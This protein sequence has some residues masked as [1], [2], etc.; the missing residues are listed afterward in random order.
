MGILAAEFG[1]LPDG[2]PVTEHTLTNRSG[3]SASILD[4]GGIVTRILVPDRFG[5]LGDVTLG[6][7]RFEGYLANPGFLGALVG[8]VGNRI[9]EGRFALNGI[10][11]RLARNAGGHHLHGGAVGF[12]AKLW[13]AEPYSDASGDHLRL[14]YTSPDGEEGYPGEL[15]VTVTYSWNEDNEL[16]IRYE[17]VSDRDTLCN[18]TNHAYFN[19]EGEGSGPIDG[20]FMTIFA[21]RI[22]AADRDL[23]P[24]GEILDV[25]GTPFDLRSGARIGDG[26]ARVADDELMGYGKGYD[27]NFALN[28]YG[29]GVRHVATASAPVS[30]RIMEMHTDLPGAQFYTAN[31]M[32]TALPGRCGRPYGPRD[33]FCFETQ[34]YPDSP[35]RPEFPDSVLRAGAA[36][37]SE[38]A[39]RFRHA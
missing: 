29:E 39:Y 14:R 6:Y 20:H 2:R 26:L 15:R 37:R 38:T 11:Y 21:D 22:T 34:F 19:L 18:L 4:Y 32:R 5:A 17:A 33:G 23:I 13:A 1:R 7:D 16:R 12:N 35:N 3:A 27:H 8:R 36:Y 10:E 24:T 28:G 25:S 31:M 9:R 30:G